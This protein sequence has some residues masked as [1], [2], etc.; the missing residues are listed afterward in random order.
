[1]RNITG[2][3]LA[4][5]AM[6]GMALGA[7][8]PSN[9]VSGQ[10]IE[11]RTADVYTGPCFANG[12]VGFGGDMAVFGWKVTKGRWQGV[13]LEGLAVVAAV[14]GR[15]TLGDPTKSAYPIQSVLIIDEKARPEQRR[16]LESLA[17]RLGGDLLDNVVR[18]V[19]R[20][21]QFDVADGNV[22]SS[23]AMLKAGEWARIQTREIREEDH[24]CSN[25]YIYYGPLTKLSHA[26]PAV[27]VTSAYEGEG[28]G[29]HWS[30]S[31]RRNAF[32]GTFE[33]GE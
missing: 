7:G 33:I 27:S 1:M 8:I 10:Y 28:L 15:H 6:A 31:N 2:M 11:A 13:P 25:E 9:H 19:Y 20:P 21:I 5:T 17:R 30:L 24:I 22:H 4:L 32:L 26:M 14:R 12:E 29:A 16:A 18:V 3:L 23:K